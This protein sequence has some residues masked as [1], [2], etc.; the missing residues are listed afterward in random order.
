MIP[1]GLDFPD[2][3]AADWF[4]RAIRSG[5]LAGASAGLTNKS[6]FKCSSGK[7]TND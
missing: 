4:E 2:D 7:N 6:Q 5:D 1:I 3:R